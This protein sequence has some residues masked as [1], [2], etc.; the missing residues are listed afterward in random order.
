LKKDLNL[1]ESFAEDCGSKMDHLPMMIMTK[2]RQRKIIE[3]C[4]G[5]G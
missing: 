1:T 5:G 2:K 3:G 4:G